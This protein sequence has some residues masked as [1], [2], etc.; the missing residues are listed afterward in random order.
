MT[1]TLPRS[2]AD[3][4]E[5]A[6]PAL[7]RTWCWCLFQA[8]TGIRKDTVAV[9]SG[10]VEVPV[11]F[12]QFACQ[13]GTVAKAMDVPD[14]TARNMMQKLRDAGRI[15]WMVSEDKQYTV[16]TIVDAEK[17]IKPA[18]RKRTSRKPANR[19]TWTDE[20]GWQ[21]VTE[22]DRADWLKAYPACDIDRQLAAMAVWCK[23]NP[24]KAHKA[25]WRRFIANWLA[26]AQ[27]KGGDVPKGNTNGTNTPGRNSGTREILPPSNV[28]KVDPYADFGRF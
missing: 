18:K 24:A 22:A 26:R 10:T 20:L 19:L 15:L 7:W 6:D 27:D 5:F 13:R 1:I 28:D 21:N 2:D 8:A 11:M 17:Y 14:S 25:N 4:A 3:S 12:G 9:G 23:A 16:I